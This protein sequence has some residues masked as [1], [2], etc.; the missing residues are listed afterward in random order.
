[1]L[2]KKTSFILESYVRDGAAD[3]DTLEGFVLQLFIDKHNITPIYMYG[4]YE[5]GSIDPLTGLWNGVVGMVWYK[6]ILQQSYIDSSKNLGW[7]WV[8]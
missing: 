8:K 6:Q 2:R 1:M 7:L 4:N 3:T 5:W